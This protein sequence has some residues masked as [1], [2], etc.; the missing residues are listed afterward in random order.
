[1]RTFAI[2]VEEALKR[3]LRS[4]ETNPRNAQALVECINQ[5]ATKD[6]LIPLDGLVNPLR[7]L[8]SGDP[9]ISADFPFPQLFRGKDIT[10]LAFEDTICSVDES[11]WV[12]HELATHDALDVPSEKDV[13]AGGIWQFVDLHKAWMLFNGACTV[14]RTG[15]YNTVLVQDSVAIKA[16]CYFR[17]RVLTGGI[18][19]NSMWSSDWVDLFST[20]KDKI[21]SEFSALTH[22]ADSNFVLWS[23]IGQADFSFRFLIY[24]DEAFEGFVDDGGAEESGYSEP[25]A[26]QDKS[27]IADLIGRNELGMVA[28]PMQK[29]VLLLKP[30]KGEKA[31]ERGAVIAYG[32]DGITALIPYSE[33][34]PTFGVRKLAD[35][36][37]F[38]RGSV[39]G[40]EDEHLIVDDRGCLWRLDANLQLDPNSSDSKLD[41]REHLSN[42][43]DSNLLVAHSPEEGEY[44]FSNGERSFLLSKDRGFSETSRLVTSVAVAAGGNIGVYALTGEEG[45]SFVTDTINLQVAGLKTVVGVEVGADLPEGTYASI[46]Y[47]NGKNEEFRQTKWVRFNTLG[48]ATVRV[49][50]DEVRVAV[51]SSEALAISYVRVHFQFPDKRF[52]R[53]PYGMASNE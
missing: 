10:L 15:F 40:G 43:N 49:H 2:V 4:R 37:V 14:F 38:S 29:E 19:R 33:P 52:T 41:Y 44:Y 50:A 28:L 20:M 47:R 32:R 8:L 11:G 30:L 42:I 3:G 12:Y 24:P 16:G 46:Y 9:A 5:R 17:G 36:G 25:T 13:T 27:L 31:G 35:F 23:T 18:T 1:M 51:R 6:G 21:P 48:Y 22:K 34:V 53:G 45:G 7:P 39:G 26:T